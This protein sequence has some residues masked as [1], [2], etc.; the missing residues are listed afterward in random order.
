VNWRRRGQPGVADINEPGAKDTAAQIASAGGKAGFI[1]TDV[2]VEAD[3][4]ALVTFAVNAS[5]ADGAFNNAGVEMAARRS[6]NSASKSGASDP[7]ST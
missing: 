7:I 5:P 4:E 3:A 1:R 2:S 6:M